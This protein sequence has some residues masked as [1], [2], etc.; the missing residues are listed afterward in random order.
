MSRRMT[1]L[2]KYILSLVNCKDG[3]DVMGMFLD[4]SAVRAVDAV[5]DQMWCYGAIMSR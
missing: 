5:S 3:E 1:Q 2:W 4:E